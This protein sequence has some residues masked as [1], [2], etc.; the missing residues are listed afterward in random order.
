MSEKYELDFFPDWLFFKSGE[1]RCSDESFLVHKIKRHLVL[2]QDYLHK[3]TTNWCHDLSV[4]FY[5]F[6]HFF[7]MKWHMVLHTF[8]VKLPLI[9]NQMLSINIKSCKIFYE[10]SCSTYMTIYKLNYYHQS[11]VIYCNNLTS[12]ACI[13]DIII[14][15]FPSP[16]LGNFK[17]NL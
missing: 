11:K 2:K 15:F 1:T 7:K 12:Q 10:L 3:L 6:F 14:F 8:S 9:K 4:L 17:L 13:L 5:F 16:N